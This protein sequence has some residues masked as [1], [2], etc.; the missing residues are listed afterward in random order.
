MQVV[1]DTSALVSLGCADSVDLH[2][3]LHDEYDVL[4]P[5]R[6]FEELE[7]TSGYRDPAAE[8]AEHALS[9]LSTDAVVDVALDP[10]F[11]LDDGENAAVSL[12]NSEAADLFLCDEYNQ[13][14]VVHA[15]LRESRLVT[16][17]KLLEVFVHCGV[18][19]SEEA[20]EAFDE[21]ASVRS[22]MDNSYVCRARDALESYDASD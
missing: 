22:W 10:D 11:P 2:G 4:V 13:I 5:R 12:A 6:V 20:L 18:V 7:E 14:G 21:V 16:T 17:P 9:Q 1:A 3:V 8:A 15:S 19:S